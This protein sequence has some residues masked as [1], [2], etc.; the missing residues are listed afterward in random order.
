VPHYFFNYSPEINRK[1]EKIKENYKFF[2]D[3]RKIKENNS[4]FDKLFNKYLQDKKKV[5]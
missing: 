1:I 3:I 2:Y 5:R 4:V